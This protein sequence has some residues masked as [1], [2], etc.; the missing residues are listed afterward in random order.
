M[1]KEIR[2]GELYGVSILEPGDVEIGDDDSFYIYYKDEVRFVIGRTLKHDGTIESIK[3]LIKDKP[4]E[5]IVIYTHKLLSIYLHFDRQK[6]ITDFEDVVKRMNE[7]TTTINRDNKLS[8][9]GIEY[10]QHNTE[11]RSEFCK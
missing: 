5:K 9:I 3:N 8:E 6:G 7:I 4:D 2:L 1:K 10:T 11:I